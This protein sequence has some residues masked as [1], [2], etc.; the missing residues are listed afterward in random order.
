MLPKRG[1]LAFMCPSFCHGIHAALFR[2]HWLLIATGIAHPT[3]RQEAMA[4]QG[5]ILLSGSLWFA[6]GTCTKPNA[7]LTA[8]Q[9]AVAL[10]TSL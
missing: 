7:N 9:K 10:R 6:S 3:A 8:W 2:E 5:Q 4:C 1:P